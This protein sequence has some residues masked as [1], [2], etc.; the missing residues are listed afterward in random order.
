MGDLRIQ[1]MKTVTRRHVADIRQ[2]EDGCATRGV[3][4]Q[5]A[6]AAT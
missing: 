5:L 2:A 6:A 1:D 3:R 4:H